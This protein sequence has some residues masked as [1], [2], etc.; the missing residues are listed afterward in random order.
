MELVTPASSSCVL[1][2]SIMK[3]DN[4]TEGQGI[5]PGCKET[6]FLQTTF[7]PHWSPSNE[8]TGA[9]FTLGLPLKFEADSFDINDANQNGAPL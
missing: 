7:A 9:M 5:Y 8:L 3:P 4:T 1:A 2:G 6:A